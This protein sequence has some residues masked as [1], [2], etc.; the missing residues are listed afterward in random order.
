MRGSSYSVGVQN[1]CMHDFAAPSVVA[2]GGVLLAVVAGAEFG[3]AIVSFGW[4]VLGFS[5][6]M[7][8]LG[9]VWRRASAAAQESSGSWLWVIVAIGVLALIAFT[10]DATDAAFFGGFGLGLTLAETLLGRLPS[11]RS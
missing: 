3:N 8:V 10:G 7:L 9:L 6:A 1:A 5:A 2:V 11:L 4:G